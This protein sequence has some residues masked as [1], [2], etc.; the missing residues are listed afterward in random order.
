VNS[1]IFKVS[2]STLRLHPFTTHRYFRA[3]ERARFLKH[4][5]KLL[6]HFWN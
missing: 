5:F 2:E 3:S 4:C 6:F 1:L